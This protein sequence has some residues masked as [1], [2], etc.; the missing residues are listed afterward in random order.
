[1]ALSILTKENYH[2]WEGDFDPLP[3][4]LLA[5]DDVASMIINAGS[6]EIDPFVNDVSSL[7]INYDSLEITLQDNPLA[8]AIYDPVSRKITYYL[9][10]DALAGQVRQIKY[11]WKD[12]AGTSS[13]EATIS[14]TV[15]ERATSFRPH[16]FSKECIKDGSGNNTGQSRYTAL[17]KYYLDDGKAL[18]PYFLVAN[19]VSHPNYVAPVDDPVSCP[20]PAVAGNDFYVYVYN[21]DSILMTVQI[22]S[23]APYNLNLQGSDTGA[24]AVIQ[25]PSGS[26]AVTL[27]INNGNPQNIIEA[28][29]STPGQALQTRHMTALG[30]ADILFD[31]IIFGT[32]FAGELTII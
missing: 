27:T 7:G 5:V 26:Q 28:N 10:N 16:T 25:V 23:M 13:N 31:D 18:K 22:G 2:Q 24:Y 29:I 4:T 32:G 17:E 21:R 12:V 3:A 11:K 20:I 30:T 14:V 19:V 15:L 9:P 8:I 6:I 1:M